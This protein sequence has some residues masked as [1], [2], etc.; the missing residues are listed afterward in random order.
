M[1]YSPLHSIFFN[2][3]SQVVNFASP[4]RL[5]QCHTI[6]E[7]KVVKGEPRGKAHMLMA[8]LIDTSAN[9]QVLLNAKRP[10]TREA[11]PLNQNGVSSKDD[12][13]EEKVPL[14]R[15]F[16]LHHE[17][18]YPS[19]KHARVIYTSLHPTFI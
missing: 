11:K 3:F 17:T 2:S 10:T 18:A 15:L 6:D 5:E 1:T 4:S 9:S 12:K 8:R 19:C 13:S 14:Q 16:E 7:M